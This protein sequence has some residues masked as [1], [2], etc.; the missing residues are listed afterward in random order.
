MMK[1]P[2]ATIQDCSALL[3]DDGGVLYQSG[4]P[5]EGAIEFIRTL[6][7]RDVP[8]FIFSNDTKYSRESLTEKMQADGFRVS[9]EHVITVEQALL[10]YLTDQRITSA[11]VIG[12]TQLKLWLQRQGISLSEHADTVLVGLDEQL[13]YE[14]LRS[15]CQLVGNG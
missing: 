2:P 14:Q 9:L 3:I 6:R 5:V 12:D 7:R 4:A 8:F 11:Y 15:A 13:T 1:P 10:R